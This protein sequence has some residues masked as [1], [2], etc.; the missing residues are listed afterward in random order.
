VPIPNLDSP[1]SP[2]NA[3]RALYARDRSPKEEG[4]LPT[5]P[6]CG[7]IPR[8]TGETLAGLLSGNYDR[9]FKELFIIDCRY[10]YEY[11]GGHIRGA[12]NANS[13]ETLI[14]GFFARPTAH[15]V[16]IFHCEFSHNRGPQ[17]AQL[18]REIDR[19]M[20]KLTY[21]NLFYPNLYVLDGGYKE[22]YAQYPQF[23][24]GGYTRMLDE[25]HRQN[26]NLTRETT[27]FRKVVE[28]LESRHRKALVATNRPVGHE[29]LKSPVGFG[30]AA[31]TSP[32]TARMLAFST[33]PLQPRRI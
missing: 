8:I 33:S 11:A 4:I 24:D 1:S 30:G 20:N 22:F 25:P 26:G 12:V 17:L 9:Y 13:P 3:N 2:T 18:F 16:M 23:C 7:T 29:L 5:L 10:G 15:A 31:E 19:D 28:Q 27:Q 14:D 21:P 6:R 32:V